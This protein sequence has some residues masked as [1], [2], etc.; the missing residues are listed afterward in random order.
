MCDFCPRN[1]LFFFR[2]HMGFE[3]GSRSLTRYVTS[4]LKLKKCHTLVFALNRTHRENRKRAMMHISIKLNFPV[5]PTRRT[6]T[7]ALFLCGLRQKSL[8]H[9]LIHSP[10]HISDFGFFVLLSGPK[11]SHALLSHTKSVPPYPPRYFSIL[12]LQSSCFEI[13]IHCFLCCECFPRHYCFFL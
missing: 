10:T 13:P 1:P 5:G 7:E 4:Q 8:T 11:F 9:S 3:P 2:Y 12:F 6:N